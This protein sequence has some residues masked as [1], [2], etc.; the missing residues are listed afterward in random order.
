LSE[1]NKLL[2]LRMIELNELVGGGEQ[3]EK[4]AKGREMARLME[5]ND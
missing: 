2:E 1:K 4:G 3:E 5:E